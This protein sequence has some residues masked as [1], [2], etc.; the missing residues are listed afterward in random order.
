MRS[1]RGGSVG[2][3]AVSGPLVAFDLDCSVVVGGVV[4]ALQLSVEV[5]EFVGDGDC[6][7]GCGRDPDAVFDQQPGEVIDIEDA[8]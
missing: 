5:R 2:A 4:E 1:S 8:D 7:T 6:S 3:V